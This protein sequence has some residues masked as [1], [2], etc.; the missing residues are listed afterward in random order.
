ME[1]KFNADARK[2]AVKEAFDDCMESIKSN[3]SQG[4][5]ETGLYIDKNIAGE[6]RELIDKEI[7]G[8][9]FTWCIVRTGSNPHTGRIEHFSG[10][11]VGNE[12]FYNLKY[13]GE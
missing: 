4:I 13:T 9:P 11:L 10:M 1:L 12:R 2:N 8:Q 5:K 3:L 7:E 6:V